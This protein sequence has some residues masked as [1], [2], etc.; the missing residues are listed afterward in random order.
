MCLTL[1]D[2]MDPFQAPLFMGFS[3][4]EY[5][6]GLSFS[7]P[8]ALPNLRIK[9]TSPALTHRFF[10]TEP[11]EKPAFY[12][13]LKQIS[14][15]CILNIVI[16]IGLIYN[17]Y[18]AWLLPNQIKYRSITINKASGGEGIP[19]DLLQILKDDAVKELHSIFQQNW[20]TQQW[21]GKP[22]KGQVLFQSQRK[23]MP[24]KVQITTQLHSSH[25]LA[26]LLL[27]I[28]QARLQ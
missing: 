6:S 21:P 8:G 12:F 1:C 16:Y 3:R 5:R 13:I 14:Y 28:L 22:G 20:K 11:P 24:K 9:F 4:Q 15:T 18:F 25:M 26:K 19:A 17:N 27:K 2:L 10:T 23:A 7:P